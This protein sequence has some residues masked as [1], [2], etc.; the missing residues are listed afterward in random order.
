MHRCYPLTSMGTLRE[1]ECVRTAV[2]TQQAST[3]T[4]ARQGTSG[5]MTRNLMTRMSASL[6]TATFSTQRGIVPKEQ[7]SVSVGQ[8][9]SHH[10]VTSV[11]RVTMT[12]L[13]ASP[14]TAPS[15]AP[16]EAC[17]KLVVASVL[18]R[19]IMLA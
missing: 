1:E 18:V 11:M 7:G 9:S 6:V 10:T 14:V 3:V 8:P 16:W 5:H 19:K 12:T 4:S 15:M 13:T 17:V 2:T